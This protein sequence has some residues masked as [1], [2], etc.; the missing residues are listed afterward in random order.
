MS[1]ELVQGDSK[2]PLRGTIT[3]ADTGDPANLADCTVFFQMR[4][5]DDQRYTINAE[6]EIVDEETG[7]V[8]YVTGPNDLNTPG[9]YQA[10]FELRFDDGTIQ[11]TKDLLEVIVRRQ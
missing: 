8:R 7:I 1:L 10:Q 9:T 2:I 5:K 6:C 3:D 4:K 11:T